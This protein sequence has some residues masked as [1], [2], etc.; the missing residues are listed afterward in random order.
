MCAPEWMRHLRN[1]NV[2]AKSPEAL[3]MQR[4]YDH[5][6]IYY[7]RQDALVIE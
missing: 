4:R 7:S 5:V 3:G 6:R 1:V 2:K